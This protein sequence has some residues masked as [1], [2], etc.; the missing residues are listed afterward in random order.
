MCKRLLAAVF[1]GVLGLSFLLFNSF[2]KQLSGDNHENRLLTGLP[3]VLQSPP[4]ELFDNLDR[5]IADNSPFRYQLVELNA[6][7]N[8][9]LFGQVQNDQVLAG[10][11]GW[12][13]YKDGPDAARPLANCQGLPDTFDGGEELAAAAASLQ[14]LADVLAEQGCTLVLDLTPSKDRVYREYLPDGYPIVNEQNRT[15]RLAACLQAN[16]GV[17]VTWQYPAIRAAALA[18]PAQPLYFKT[19]THWNRAGALMGLDGALTAA[20]LDCVPYAEYDIAENGTQTGDLANVAALYTILP[21]DTDYAAA[22]Y[23]ALYEQDPRTVGV[24]GDSFSEYYMGYLSRRFAASWR[25]TYENA[26]TP[27]LTEAPGCD[28][29]ILQVAERKLDTLLALLAQF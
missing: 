27:A 29:L 18:D 21:A 1:C 22:N 11:D 15:D 20:G 16:T 14:R 13:F 5:F 25:D 24:L 17:P 6:N 19:D 2:S 7:A 12:L 8:Y 9:L 4:L 23:A 26:L 3:A 28:I 10:R